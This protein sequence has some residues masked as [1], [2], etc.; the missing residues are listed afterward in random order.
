MEKGSERFVLSSQNIAET[1][2]LVA[3]TCTTE[4]EWLS[5]ID[6]IKNY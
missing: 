5:I 1:I 4:A 6:N 3:L 2:I